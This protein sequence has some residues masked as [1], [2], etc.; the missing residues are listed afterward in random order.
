[1][2]NYMTDPPYKGYKLG[3]ETITKSR[4]ETLEQKKER[5]RLTRLKK[6]R[7]RGM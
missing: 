7:K 2:S 1:M 5:K 6:L 4:A 3:D